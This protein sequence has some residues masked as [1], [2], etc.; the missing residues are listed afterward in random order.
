MQEINFKKERAE[1]ISGLYEHLLKRKPIP[2]EIEYWMNSDYHNQELLKIFTESEEYLQ[3]TTSHQLT[4]KENLYGIAVRAKEIG[5]YLLYPAF[6]R[7][8]LPSILNGEPF[9]FS[10]FVSCLQFLKANDWLNPQKK[11]FLDLGANIGSTS[12]YALKGGY[13][14]HAISIEA[15]RLNYDFLKF[16]AK[17][18]D[19]ENNIQSFNYGIAD[20]VGEKNLVCNPSNCGDFRIESSA[21]ETEQQNL[22]DE[23]NYTTETAD[24]TTLDELFDRGI[25]KQ[26]QL[27]FIWIDCQGSEGFIFQGGEKFFKTIRVP[28][29]VEFWPYGMERLASKNTFFSFIQQYSS[30][31]FRL[32]EGEF[33]PISFEFLDEFYSQK[34]GT[35]D[36]FDILVIPRTL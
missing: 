20:F 33:Q 32:I 36:Y 25:L 6:D 8:Q 9:Q 31:I 1:L 15:S 21:S 34:L 28:L 29:Y 24:F 2:A 14:D 18:N 7:V 19:L 10:D 4:D 13:F 11:S 12:I 17:L 26:D 5:A 35:G 16:N 30:R 22:F 27:G 3:L 23:E